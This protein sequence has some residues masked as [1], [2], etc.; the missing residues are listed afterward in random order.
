MEHNANPWLACVVDTLNRTVV[1]VLEI[2]LP[3]TYNRILTDDELRQNRKVD[4]IR[5]RGNFADYANLTVVNAQ[6]DGLAEGETAQG[7]MADGDY[8]LTGSMTFTAAP[9]VVGGRTLRPRH[10]VETKVDGVWTRKARVFGGACTL[11]AGAALL[12][13][14]L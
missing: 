13:T 5:Y 9:V 10:T 7:S 12:A 6:P 14:A 2:Y 3:L 1:K 4:E 8:E 11:S